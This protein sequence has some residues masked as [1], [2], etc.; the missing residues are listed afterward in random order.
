M[1]IAN[2]KNSGHSRLF[3]KL[4][5]ESTRQFIKFSGDKHCYENISRDSVQTELSIVNHIF[6]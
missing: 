5:N 4:E 3:S 2:L 6:D 1:V